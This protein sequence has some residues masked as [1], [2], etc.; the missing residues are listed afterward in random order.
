M[1]WKPAAA[2]RS[3]RRGDAEASISTTRSYNGTTGH[4]CRPAETG[5]AD[6]R[7]GR[8]GAGG[9]GVQSYPAQGRNSERIL[10][11]VDPLQNA[12]STV[13][14]SLLRSSPMSVG[15]FEFAW[16]L[17]VG[18]AIERATKPTLREDGTVDVLVADPAWRREV[19]RSQA[20]ILAKLQELLS[21]SIVKKLKIIGGGR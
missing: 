19:K 1:N 9:T 2:R 3:A 7:C 5:A 20:V 18:P 17:A 4:R 12:A 8:S 16:R 6:R 21:G 13:V 11:V 15:K 10:L 14:R